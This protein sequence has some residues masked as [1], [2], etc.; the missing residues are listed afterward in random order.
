VNQPKKQTTSQN[1]P[2]N[3]EVPFPP[4]KKETTHQKRSSEAQHN[5][6]LTD[7][8]IDEKEEVFP[9]DVEE[10]INHREDKH[11]ESLK[12]IKISNR[13]LKTRCMEAIDLI[14][15]HIDMICRVQMEATQFKRKQPQ[16]IGKDNEILQQKQR[17][18]NYQEMQLK[19][20]R[21]EI[22]HLQTIFMN[23]RTYDLMI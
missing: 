4:P 12:D 19:E 1:R 5:D 20:M 21:K 8:Q 6:T 14:E 13:K 2:S 23:E 3:Y 9:Y 16:E 7:N 10:S 22:E 18:V 17:E 15:Q 11:I